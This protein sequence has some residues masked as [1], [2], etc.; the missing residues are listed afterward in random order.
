MAH[1][2]ASNCFQAPLRKTCCGHRSQPRVYL[3]AFPDSVAVAAA[4]FTNSLW[5]E[6]HHKCFRL[7]CFS[8]PA[9]PIK[10]LPF[11]QPR[12]EGSERHRLPPFPGRLIHFLG[13][14]CDCRAV[15][16]GTNCLSASCKTDSKMKTAA[17]GGIEPQPVVTYCSL[18]HKSTH[19]TNRIKV[20]LDLP[21][22]F[23]WTRRWI[24]M[25]VLLKNL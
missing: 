1:S 13:L 20:I 14:R 19:R 5:T 9:A 7:K 10:P 23:S 4:H 2:A 25:T 24:W 22:R 17:G 8:Q 16:Q 12:E 21:A 18:N 15:N 11:T 6:Q 3:G